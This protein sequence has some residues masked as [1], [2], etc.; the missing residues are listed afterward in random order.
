MNPLF[1]ISEANLRLKK[2]VD[3]GYTEELQP[4]TYAHYSKWVDSGLSGN[5]KYL[6]DHRKEKRENLQNVFPDCSSALVFLFDYTATKKTLSHELNHAKIASYTLGFEGVDYHHWIKAKLETI[7]ESLKIQFKDLEYQISLDVH[8]VLE[9]DLSERSGL[10]WFGK[11]TMLISKKYGSYHL[12]GS[13]LLNQKLELETRASEPNHCGSCTLCID[14]C[15]TKAISLTGPRLDA[16]KCISTFTIEEFKDTTA[17]I[18][19]PTDSNEIFGCDICQEVCPWNNKPLLNSDEET[20]SSRL[21]TFFN[22]PLEDIYFDIEKM[23][24]NE[25]KRF[26]HSTSFERSGKRGLLKNLKR[27]LNK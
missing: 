2:I 16:S 9:R 27:S 17:P 24:N 13:L 6:Q 20:T 18:G 7:G 1:E 19:F 23:S 26:F 4:R 3:W 15:P 11:N 21:V 14:A 25:Y 12:I 5:L 22:R 10:G 8:P